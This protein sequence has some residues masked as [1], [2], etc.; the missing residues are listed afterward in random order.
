M[1]TRLRTLVSVLLLLSVLSWGQGRRD[2]NWWRQL[3]SETRVAFM[4]GFL[5]GIHMGTNFSYWGD[6]HVNG[7]GKVDVG[8]YQRIQA[9]MRVMAKKYMMNVETGQLSD[10]I[11]AFYGDYRNRSILVSDAVWIA[12]RSIAGDPQ[13]EIDQTVVNLRKDAAR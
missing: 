11:T 6:A 13:A 5:D 3:D 12:L 1:K 2:G 7:T 4:V 9:S 10:G 8:F